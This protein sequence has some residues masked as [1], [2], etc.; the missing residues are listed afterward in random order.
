[1]RRWEALPAR[2]QAAIAFPVAALLMFLIHIGP[3]NQPLG[4]A[5]GYAVFWGGVL[6]A[7][8]VVASR[9]ERHK[10]LENERSKSEDDGHE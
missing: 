3:F 9:A 2:T 8:L 7:L 1:M 10:R 6:T 5:I 4:R